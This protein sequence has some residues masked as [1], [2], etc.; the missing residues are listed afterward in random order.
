MTLFKRF[1]ESITTLL[2]FDKIFE[3]R[4]YFFWYQIQSYLTS[5]QKSRF[6]CK[7]LVAK[8]G[9]LGPGSWDSLNFRTNPSRG[10][11]LWW[12]AAKF[13]WGSGPDIFLHV[14]KIIIQYSYIGVIPT[15][16]NISI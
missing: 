9:E 4:S 16:L 2:S 6:Q 7:N 3:V 10:G 13:H 14:D 1:V 15:K 8:F 11:G 12:R 5:N